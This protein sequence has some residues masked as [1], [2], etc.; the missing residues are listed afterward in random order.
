MSVDM[1]E[2]PTSF[3]EFA[4]D[5]GFKDIEEFY[6]NGSDLI[7]VFRVKQWLEHYNKLRKAEIDTAYECGKHA[8]KWISVKEE[9]YPRIEDEYKYFLVTDNKGNVSVQE[10][11]VSL[12]EEPQPYFSGVRNV[13]AWQPLPMPYKGENENG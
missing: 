11:F 1:M 6:A 12:D 3:D 5:Y 9:G 2:F 7:P 8:D 13:V 4:K 10:F